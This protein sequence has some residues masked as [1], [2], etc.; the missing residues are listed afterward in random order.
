MS[1]I[2]HIC[3]LVLVGLTVG[4]PPIPVSAGQAT[5]NPNLGGHLFAAAERGDLRAVRALLKKGA[6][7]NTKGPRGEPVLFRVLSR[8]DISDVKLLLDSGADPNLTDA[9]GTTPFMYVF[10]N[11]RYDRQ[12]QI[13]HMLVAAGADVNAKNRSGETAA[14]LVTRRGQI[15]RLQLLKELGAKVDEKIILEARLYDL[16]QRGSAQEVQRLLAS[17]V[18][19]NLKVIKDLSV[20]PIDLPLHAAI[21][22]GHTRTAE[23]LLAARADPEAQGRGA[24]PLFAAIQGGDPEMV[25]LLL[26][27]GAN[28]NVS[29][30]GGQTALMSAAASYSERRLEIVRLIVAAGADV[31]A[32]NSAGVT[33]AFLAAERGFDEVARFLLALGSGSEAKD[34][35]ALSLIR[36]AE[37]G[38]L[39][40]VKELLAKGVDVNA[41]TELSKGLKRNTPLIAA[42]RRSRVEI[43]TFLLTARANPNLSGATGENALSSAVATGNL[44]IIRMLLKHGADP[45]IKNF[46]GDTPLM[47]AITTGNM[48]I[49][50]ILLDH[51]AEANVKNSAGTSPLMYAVDGRVRDNQKMT[52]IVR[53]LIAAGADVN[54]KDKQGR[55][56]LLFA[57]QSRNRETIELLQ[58]SGAKIGDEVLAFYHTIGVGTPESVQALISLGVNIEVRNQF[59]STPLMHAARMGRG[60]IVKV[61]LDS[62]ANVNVRDA[63]GFTPLYHAAYAGYID[64][65]KALL[66]K[67]ADV[68]AKINGETI[69]SLLARGVVA[70][71]SARVV[72]GGHPTAII[73]GGESS[74]APSV[75]I[76]GPP[77]GEAIEDLVEHPAY[78]MS[79]LLEHGAD[80]NIADKDGLTP[81]M[82]AAGKGRLDLVKTLLAHGADV[83]AKGAYGITASQLAIGDDVIAAL[84][85]ARKKSKADKPK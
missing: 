24:T 25:R 16:A 62:G 47:Y 73:V 44:D 2:L 33:A 74:L 56:V 7:P 23:I 12:I 11:T 59:G 45:N 81:L 35:L 65:I 10:G 41:Q 64:V 39:N 50:K 6:D 70:G 8:G 40:A 34:I 21:Q 76:V 19:P 85:E 43:V 80:P 69:V 32:K 22:G 37:N 55:T 28:V 51:G 84:N 5:Y 14:D 27:H 52:A 83:N 61:L 3:V 1:L 49:I 71:R 15:G 54:G 60:S 72:E 63:K 4:L 48:D 42:V 9:D 18:D 82:Y 29:Y 68:N 58:R 67:G 20:Y 75:A 38:D 17:G 53:M 79:L 13:A 46:A 26:K 31:N 77:A 36:A 30:A 66:S 78:M 57:V